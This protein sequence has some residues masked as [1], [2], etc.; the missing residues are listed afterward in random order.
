GIKIRAPIVAGGKVKKLISHGVFVLHRGMDANHILIDPGKGNFAT[1]L[2][3]IHA[4]K[5]IAADEVVIE[6]NEP[7]VPQFPWGGVVLLDVWRNKRTSNRV[8]GF[9]RIRAQPLTILR[10]HSIARINS[11]QR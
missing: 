5:G 6:F 7:A 2:V 10:K 4:S 1:I 9:I 3:W 8:V 11:R